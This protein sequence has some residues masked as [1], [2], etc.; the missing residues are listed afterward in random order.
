[1]QSDKIQLGTN[2]A[3]FKKNYANK[4]DF[5]ELFEITSKLRKEQEED[6]NLEKRIYKQKYDIEELDDRLLITRQRLIDS[7]KNLADNISAFE[8]LENLRN[9]RNANRETYDNLSKYELIDKR[10]KLKSLEEIIMLPDISYDELNRLKK[11]KL[12]LV[13]QIEQLENKV[14]NSASKSPELAIYKQNAQQASAAK[15]S[16]TRVLEK[17]EKEKMILDGKYA[18]MEKKFEQTKGF[19]FVKKDDILQQAENVKKKKE[20]YVKYNKILDIIKGDSLILDR[21]INIIKSKADNPE[22]I[23]KRIEEKY[24]ITGG[25]HAERKELEHLSRVKQDIDTQ[26][27]NTLEEYSKLIN[28]VLSKIQEKSEQHKPILKEHEDIKKEHE[29]SQTV[30]NQ[31]KQGYDKAVYDVQNQYNKTKEEFSKLEAGMKNT[32]NKYHQLNIN[33][34]ITDDLLK[35]YEMEN[36]Y[37]NKQDKRMNEHFK[38]YTEYYRAIMSQQ[39]ELMKDLKERQ[40]TM[41]DHVEDGNRQVKFLFIFR[42]NFIMI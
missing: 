40:R 33:T 30:Y 35:K 28:Q 29:Y 34:K 9:Q 25:A 1:L 22:S 7:K 17:L 13:N 32:Q 27:V 10:S 39:E 3:N 41:K 2:I 37:L 20:I 12:D 23:I 21:T 24:G 11:N 26:K 38:S 14:K 31:K 8:L 4:K 18:E 42:L 15:E 5:Q 6:S 19:K 36:L 16:T